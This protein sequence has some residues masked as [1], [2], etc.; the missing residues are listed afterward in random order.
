M[1]C[2]Q[3]ACQVSGRRSSEDTLQHMQIGETCAYFIQC[4]T[5][6]ESQDA[7]CLVPIFAK[8]GEGIGQHGEFS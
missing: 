1:A 7:K 4:K 8:F 6:N 3:F 5:K 2:E